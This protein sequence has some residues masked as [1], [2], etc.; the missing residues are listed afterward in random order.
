[1][2]DDCGTYLELCLSVALTLSL[3]SSS[4]YN[5]KDKIDEVLNVCVEQSE[6]AEDCHDGVTSGGGALLMPLI[7]WAKADRRDLWA[8]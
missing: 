5:K 2:V 8:V 4:H 7:E 6:R 1:M 3:S